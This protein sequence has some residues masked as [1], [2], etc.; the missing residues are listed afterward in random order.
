MKL[1]KKITTVLVAVFVWV[2]GGTKSLLNLAAESAVDGR[3]STGYPQGG[4]ATCE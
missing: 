3:P 2:A 1:Q 4:G